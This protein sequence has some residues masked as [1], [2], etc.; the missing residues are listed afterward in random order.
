MANDR[1]AENGAAARRL[2]K[3]HGMPMA[4]PGRRNEIVTR[5]RHYAL[6]RRAA[7]DGQSEE[8]GGLMRHLCSLLWLLLLAPAGW[9]QWNLSSITNHVLATNR[10]DLDYDGE[11]DLL[12]VHEQRRFR[13]FQPFEPYRAGAVLTSTIH[14]LGNLQL[15]HAPPGALSPLQAP[16]VAINDAT[17][18]VWTNAPLVVID[19][20]QTQWSLT[21]SDQQ[22]EMWYSWLGVVRDGP[23]LN[24]AVGFVGTRLGNGAPRF[25]WLSLTRSFHKATANHFNLANQPNQDAIT[26]QIPEPQLTYN[27]APA[28]NPPP[29]RCP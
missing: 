28:G 2:G 25:G 6:A 12:I 20:E 10:M 23:L 19:Y 24:G 29:H 21:Q 1:A 3:G 7:V 17:P 11:P 27:P 5:L 26:G 8:S 15:L 18:G 13:Y 9:C 22:L 14:P 4:R 16:Q